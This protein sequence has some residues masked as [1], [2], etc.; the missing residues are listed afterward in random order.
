MTNNPIIGLLGFGEVGQILGTDMLATGT[1]TPVFDTKFHKND[2]D[3]LN[4]VKDNKAAQKSDFPEELCQKVD[5]LIS[6]V[7]AEQTLQAATSVSE[8]IKPDTWYVDLNSASPTA[9]I[10]AANTINAAGA[11]YVEASI[12]S[13]FP[14]KRLDTP[15][16]LGGPF[17]EHFLPIGNAIGL[18]NLKSYS[19]NYGQTSAA[20]MCRSVMI[21]GMEALLSESLISARAYGVEDIVLYSLDDLFPGIKWADFANYMIGRTLEHGGRRAEE[22]REVAKTVQ[23][24]G[25]TP[26]MSLA[27]AE[28]QNWAKAFPEIQKI[29]ALSGML[30]AL[31]KIA[32]VEKEDT[33]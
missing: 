6:A 9:K 15:I 16:L 7:T 14:P 32:Q 5:I 19:S 31:G 2:N 3:I 28:R 10:E 27:T 13:P 8:H 25:L 4:A 30:D 11:K 23:N 17:A 24:I 21:K 33:K 1:N 20:K 12:M 22:M 18:S 26:H 29:D